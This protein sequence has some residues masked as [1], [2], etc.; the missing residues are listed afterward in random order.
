MRHPAANERQQK[1]LIE[2]AFGGE[3]T[4]HPITGRSLQH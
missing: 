4:A 3:V 1:A 2:L